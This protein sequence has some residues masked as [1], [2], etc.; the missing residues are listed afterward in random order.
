MIFMFLDDSVLLVFI[1][2]PMFTRGDK[3]RTDFTNRTTEETKRFE[4]ERKCDRLEPFRF[5]VAVLRAFP[6]DDAF[7]TT[8]T[9]RSEVNGGKVVAEGNLQDVIAVVEHA[10][11]TFGRFDI[12]RADRTDVSAGFGFAAASSTSFLR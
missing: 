10:V 8:E 7:V 6:R 12:A 1:F 9:R 11:E 3:S 2:V 5:G 4:K